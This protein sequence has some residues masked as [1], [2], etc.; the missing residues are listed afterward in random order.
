LSYTPRLE[1]PKIRIPQNLPLGLHGT[2][3]PLIAIPLGMTG[4]V[5][6]QFLSFGSRGILWFNVITIPYTLFAPWIA[7]VMIGYYLVWKYLV[8]F[9]NKALEIF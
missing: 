6:L 9:C 3:L 7:V 4:A 2:L 8:G 5:T 1:D